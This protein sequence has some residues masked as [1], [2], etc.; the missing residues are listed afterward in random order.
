MVC[1]RTANASYNL[2]LYSHGCLP[3]KPMMQA[4]YSL[5]LLKDTVAMLTAV[6]NYQTI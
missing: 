1:V 5:N 2:H 6:S 3:Y 4:H